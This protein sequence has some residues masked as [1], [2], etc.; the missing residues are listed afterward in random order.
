M[1]NRNELSRVENFSDAVFAIAAT[2]LVLELKAPAINNTLSK[3][4]VWKEMGNLWPSYMAF[5]LSFTTIIIIWINHHYTIRLLNK[6][7][8]SF[9]YANAFVL[10]TISFFPFPT[11]ILA[12]SIYTKNSAVGVVIYSTACL[13]INFAFIIWW[14]SMRKPVYIIKQEITKTRVKKIV[15]QLWFGLFIYLLTTL[16]SFW[17]PT[18]GII[19]IVTLNILWITMSIRDKRLNEN[20]ERNSHK[21]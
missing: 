3:T 20:V 14:L 9:L 13:L 2:I 8:K 7:S 6:I 11:K 17:L 18:I 15:T 16:I 10:L 1:S 12:D 19:I 4:E 21:G 5:L